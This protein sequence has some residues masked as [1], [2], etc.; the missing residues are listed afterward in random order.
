MGQTR[1]FSERIDLAK[2]VP[3]SE[4]SHSHY[5]LANPGQS[6]LVY[7][8]TEMTRRVQVDLRS[9]DGWLSVEWYNPDTGNS[10]QGEKVMGGVKKVFFSPFTNSAALYLNKISA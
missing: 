8:P 4:L 6:Y 2:M 5:C 1:E 10:I 7:Y 9:C 3:H